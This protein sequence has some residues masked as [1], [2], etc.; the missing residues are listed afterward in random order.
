MPLERVRPWVM[1]A[2]PCVESIAHRMSEFAGR[3]L[4]TRRP[5]GSWLE[6]Y[7]LKWPLRPLAEQVR[8]VGRH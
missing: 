8:V 7:Q 5:R 4:E 1:P 6:E 2:P 3:Y